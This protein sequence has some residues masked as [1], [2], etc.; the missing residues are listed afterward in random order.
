MSSRPNARS[1]AS[2]HGAILRIGDV[3]GARDDGAAAS[4]DPLGHLG[5]G[6]FAPCPEHYVSAGLAEGLGEA[7]AQTRTGAGDYRDLAVQ[8]EPVD[9]RHDG[10]DQSVRRSRHHEC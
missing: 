10:A 2:Q 3:S 5:Q 7:T 4:A 6:I 9:D 1:G 8:A